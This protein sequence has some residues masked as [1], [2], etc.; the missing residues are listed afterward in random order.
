MKKWLMFESLYLC[1]RHHVHVSFSHVQVTYNFQT[2]VVSEFWHIKT[3][4]LWGEGG[5][6][7]LQYMYMCCTGRMIYVTSAL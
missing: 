2:F 7:T 1:N 6:S 4:S 3:I 5:G